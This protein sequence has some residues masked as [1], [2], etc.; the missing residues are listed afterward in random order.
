LARFLRVTALKSAQGR[1]IALA[2][3]E[4]IDVVDQPRMTVDGRPTGGGRLAGRSR[5]HELGWRGP[6][7]TWS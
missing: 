2:E 1:R 3:L 4:I 5:G 6:A 7:A